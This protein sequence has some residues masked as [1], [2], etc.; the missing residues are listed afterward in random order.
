MKEIEMY[1]NIVYYLECYIG[2]EVLQNEIKFRNQIKSVDMLGIKNGEFYII[3]IKRN[4]SPGN[5]VL[6]DYANLRYIIDNNKVGKKLKGILISNTKDEELISIVE[7][8]NEIE[9]ISFEN[10]FFSEKLHSDKRVIKH[11]NEYLNDE[12]KYFRQVFLHINNGW[13]VDLYYDKDKVIT[14]YEAGGEKYYAISHN[15]NKPYADF[16]K[17]M[18]KFENNIMCV[19]IKNRSA[20]K[21]N[22]IIY[23]EVLRINKEFLK[24]Y[25]CIEDTIKFDYY[26]EVYSFLKREDIFIDIKNDKENYL[27]LDSQYLSFY[28]G[29]EMKNINIKKIALLNKI[30]YIE[31]SNVFIDKYIYKPNIRI[32]TI[33]TKLSKV[34]MKIKMTKEGNV[35]DN[36][37]GFEIK[38]N[39]ESPD[40]ND[41][42][43]FLFLNF[44]IIC[45]FEENILK[46]IEKGWSIDDCHRKYE[47]EIFH[48]KY[49]ESDDYIET[50]RDVI[51]RLTDEIRYY[52]KK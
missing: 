38:S 41:I 5:K 36:K 44:R 4:G 29:K 9:I 39:L 15:P 12:Y 19:E 8:D 16:Y 48:K 22:D 25:K 32:E 23:E 26:Y 34:I 31:C 45:E 6:E 10:Q 3:E 35:K 49:K 30:N 50:I 21:I 2:I 20:K 14:T 18:C 28:K 11:R 42:E 24:K 43:L 17:K 27:M 46:D 33:S 37:F 40:Y 13:I 51:F 52:K 7:R 47:L 1:N